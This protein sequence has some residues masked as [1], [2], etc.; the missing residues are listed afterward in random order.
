MLGG[1]VLRTPPLLRDSTSFRFPKIFQKVPKNIIFFGLFFN[2]L[3]AAQKIGEKTGS[4][5]FGRA[6]KINLVD[7][8]KKFDK[9]FEVFLKIRP[10]QENPRSAPAWV[11]I[12]IVITPQEQ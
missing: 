4:F 12:F 2:I 5:L 3:S 9:I 11:Q 10:P 1:S 7:L 8:K 6:R